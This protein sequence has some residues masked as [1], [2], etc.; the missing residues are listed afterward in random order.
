M[1]LPVS[2]NV[3]LVFGAISPP[4]GDITGLSIKLGGTNKVSTFVVTLRN[5][6]GKYGVGGATP[7]TVGMDGSISMGRTPYCPL[8]ITCRVEDVDIETSPT[9]SYATISGRCWGEKLFRY[10]VTKNYLAQKGEYIV[11]DILDYYAGLSHARGGVELVANTDTTYSDLEYEDSPAWD[12]LKYIAETS[13][14]SG[15]IGFDF[16]VEPDGKFA[17]FAKGSKYH[18][19]L[20]INEPGSENVD[21]SSRYRKNISRVRNRIKI[22]GLADKSYPT[23]KVSWTRSLTPADGAWASGIGTVSLDATGAPDGGAC[24]KVRVGSSYGNVLDLNFTAGHEPDCNL[25]PVI[26]LQIKAE[27]SFSGNGFILLMDD[28]VKFASKTISVS[29]DGEFHVLEMGVGDAYANQWENVDAGFNWSKITKIR[30]NQGFPTGVGSGSFWVHRMYVGGRRFAYQSDDVTSQAAY[31]IR[32]YVETDEELWTD[33]ECMLRAKSLLAFLKDPDLFITVKSSLFSYNDS[34]ILPGDSIKTWL[35]DAGISDTW[36]RVDTIEYIIPDGQTDR[37]EIKIDLERVHP[38]MAD[39]LYGLRTFTVNVEKLSRTKTGKR[40]IPVL[41]GGVMGAPSRF[42]TNLEIDKISPV[43]N[44]YHSSALKAAFGHDGSNGF[45][46]IYGGDLVLYSGGG[47]ILPDADGSQN[48]GDTAIARRFGALHL[49]NE[50]WVAGVQTVDTTGRVTMAGLPRDAAGKIIEAQGT[51]FYPMYVDPNG[52]YVPAAHTHESLVSSTRHVEMDPTN[53]VLNFY[54][55]V[56]LKGAIG[57]DTA[58]FFVV[59][60]NGNLILYSATGLIQPNTDGGQDLGSSSYAKRFGTIHLKNGVVV[61]GVQTVDSDGRV[62]M[63]AIPR[64]TAG[65]VLEAQGTGFYPMYVN[66]NGRYAPA[67]HESGHANL[68]PSGGSNSGQVGNTSNYWNIIAT[69][70]MW[71]KAAGVF[72]CDPALAKREITRDVQSR[73]QAEEILTHELTK[74]WCHMPYAR[75]KKHKGK[76]IC[77]CGSAMFEPCPE[78]REAWEDRYIVNTGAQLEATAWLVLELSADVLRLKTELAAVKE[79][80]AKV[81]MPLSDRR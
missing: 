34:A 62:T 75:S 42:T 66:P 10:T 37:L 80:L 43:L 69:N 45:L 33:N 46:T 54:D 40:G 15:A 81:G 44:L 7:I 13:D 65:L 58:N 47:K 17:F 6:N 41:A 61:A 77:T 59:A 4:Q 25:Y 48:L 74:T 8:L 78:H 29:P 2:P 35:S 76:I 39:Y 28:A 79:N 56:N 3:A 49:K 38:Q 11:K 14:K 5:T 30:I 51:G 23:D 64:D 32:E 60:Y 53:A 19:V 57:H 31:G 12:I 24:V 71:Y 22:Y 27:T 50:L 1:S 68:Y 21:I 52:R 55:G 36:L 73:S 9:E 72:G 26:G 63:S 18:N 70:S 20:K 16:R 67:A